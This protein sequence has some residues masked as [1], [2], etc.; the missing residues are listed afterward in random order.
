MRPAGGHDPAVLTAVHIQRFAADQRHR[1]RE[2]LA[3]LAM[4][5]QDGTP[6][7]VTTTTRAITFNHAR[8]LL[9]W[10]LEAGAAE[11]IGLRDIWETIIV[12]GRRGS[13]VLGLRLDCTDGSAAVTYQWFHLRFK[14]WVDELDIGRWVAHQARHT[15]ATSL[16]R[17]CANFVLSG[18]ALS[19][20]IAPRSAAIARSA[21]AAA[22]PTRLS[23]S[24]PPGRSN[25]LL[26]AASRLA[27]RST[28]S[29]RW[30]RAWSRSTPGDRSPS[31]HACDP[32]SSLL[33]AFSVRP[34]QT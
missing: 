14:A 33:P 15:L 28:R 30:A 4:R 32:G 1:E 16:L 10:A 6:S 8:K 29:C 2:E 22:R 20:W 19:P 26:R 5:R 34:P 13:E 23:G 12:T 17:P 7:A 25:P 24:G 21:S 27:T 3:S 18:A 11:Q 31:S 9:R